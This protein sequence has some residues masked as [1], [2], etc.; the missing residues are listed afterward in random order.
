MMD[1]RSRTMLIATVVLFVVLM[2]KSIWIDPAGINI[3]EDRHYRNF[4]LE[5]APELHNSI[6]LKTGLLTYR[7]TSVAKVSE[8]GA[9]VVEYT[10]EE[11]NVVHEEMAG[12]YAAKA[13]VYVL[14]ILP[15]KD[16]KIE[17]GL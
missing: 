17:G 8:E 10:D 14:Y 13:R 11:G 3:E 1:K 9:T 2:I 4:A 15:Y 5:V 12:Q 16:F 6:L 7:I